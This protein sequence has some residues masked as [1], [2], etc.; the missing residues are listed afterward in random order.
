MPKQPVV[1]TKNGKT[2]SGASWVDYPVEA[3]NKNINPP[4]NSRLKRFFRAAIN[5]LTCSEESEQKADV[6]PE[7]PNNLAQNPNALFYN[8]PSRI[9]E[10]NSEM[11]QDKERPRRA[12]I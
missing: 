8:Q 3:M 5:C 1:L 11:K 12:S 10:S 4:S 9:A 7:S 6:A 2:I